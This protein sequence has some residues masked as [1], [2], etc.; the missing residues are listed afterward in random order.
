MQQDTEFNESIVEDGF[1]EDVEELVPVSRESSAS[2]A[3][4]SMRFLVL[5]IWL[6]WAEDLFLGFIGG[7]LATGAPG[8][9]SKFHFGLL[10]TAWEGW[11]FI[12]FSLFSGFLGV[13]KNMTVGSRSADFSKNRSDLTTY[14]KLQEEFRSYKI[15]LLEHRE[16]LHDPELAEGYTQ[17]FSAHPIL[18]NATIKINLIRDMREKLQRRY[19]NGCQP[20]YMVMVAY[21]VCATTISMGGL[22]GFLLLTPNAILGEFYNIPNWVFNLDITVGT[23]F[24]LRCGY[25]EIIREIGVYRAEHKLIEELVAAELETQAE[26]ASCNQALDALNRAIEMKGVTNAQPGPS[27]WE[28]KEPLISVEAWLKSRE[29]GAT[30]TRSGIFSLGGS[31]GA[32]LFPARPKPPKFLA[33]RRHVQEDV[34]DDRRSHGPGD[35][36]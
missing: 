25:K 32:L 11:V 1:D 6:A 5:M 31:G 26:L 24:G 30:F 16:N 34:Q 4:F 7:F 35:T 13:A 8:F 3:T 9:F 33:R 20:G 27:T 23:V 18:E 2:D 10:K 21:G 29:A 36:L 12:A 15:N 19:L 14:S 17:Q 28:P 22:V